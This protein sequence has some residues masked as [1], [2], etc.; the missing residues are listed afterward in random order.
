MMHLSRSK[1]CWQSVRLLFTVCVSCVLLTGAGTAPQTDEPRDTRERYIELDGEIQ[2]IKE[3]ILGINRDIL[4]LEE[5]SLYPHGQQ[6]VILVSVANNSPVNPD[7]ILLQLDGDTVSHHRY[8]GSEGAALQEGG[9]HR[10]YTG[11]LSDG[12]HILKVSVTGR[13]A[14]GQSFNQQRSVTITK[15]PGRKYM[16]LHLGP[17]EN[18]SEPG[19]TIREW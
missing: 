19:L 16:E 8:T 15:V 17:G 10:L 11:R 13:Q 4:L 6:L 1:Q 5:L 7:S 3:E 9:V 18:T 2:A 12:E 14:K